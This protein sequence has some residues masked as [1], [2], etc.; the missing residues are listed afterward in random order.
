M[1]DK[2]KLLFINPHQFGHTAGYYYYC[3]YLRTEYDIKYLGFDERLKK[4]VMAGTN[5]IYI[6]QKKNKILRILN[7][8][9]NSIRESYRCNYDILYVYSFYLSFI[10][11]LFAKKSRKI[12]DIRTCSVSANPLKRRLIN[13]LLSFNTLFFDR[14]I[15][16]SPDLIK[17]LI[18]NPLKYH[19]L[20]LGSE[21]YFGEN[22][23][24]D[25][26]RLLY[27][28][29]LN[30]RNIY[31][32]IEGLYFFLERNNFKPHISY[33]IV[34]FGNIHEEDTIRESIDKYGLKE[35]VVFDGRRSY[36]ELPEYFEKCNIG[37]SWIPKTSVFDQ[38]PATKTFE[39]LMSGLFCMAT[40]TKANK[41]LINN[42]NGIL[43][44]DN[45]HDFADALEDVYK[46]KNKY[47]SARIRE[48]VKEYS[49][50][51]LV[52]NNLLPFLKSL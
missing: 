4:L 15:V 45:A 37:V 31:Q 6:Q 3:K 47:D 5:V 11:G 24:F 38:Q 41:D 35:Y 49:W 2:E 23:T 18:I 39:Y 14:V 7:F 27:V 25:D 51:N 17:G 13:R 29:A 36:D 52:E 33:T 19:Y 43:F 20:P 46:N 10:I 32:S 44:N 1:S 48:T 12:L 9:Y 42:S 28:G 22:H 16:L 8:L 40:S 50:Q 21:K 30:T 26:L 34:G